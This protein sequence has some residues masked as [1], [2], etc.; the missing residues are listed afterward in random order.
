MGERVGG[1]EEIKAVLMIAHNTKIL[2]VVSVENLP[3]V[4]QVF[5][6]ARTNQLLKNNLENVI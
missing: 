3:L 6:L 4:K 1:L 2:L 5:R